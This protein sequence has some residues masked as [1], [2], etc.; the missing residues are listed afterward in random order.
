MSEAPAVLQLTVAEVYTL[1]RGYLESGHVQAAQSA[2]ER[3]LE[4]RP[5]DLRAHLLAG[6]IYTELGER[7]RAH[8]HFEQGLSADPQDAAG[9]LGLALLSEQD[10][11]QETAR[12]EYLTVA[13]LE[14]GFPGLWEHLR[15]RDLPSPHLTRGT[16]MLQRLRSGDPLGAL[17]EWHALDE[18]DQAQPWAQ[19]ALLEAVWMAGRDV[20]AEELARQMLDTVPGSIK[21]ALVLSFYQALHG[22]TETAE[23]VLAELREFDPSG[24]YLSAQMY[25]APP[26]WQLPDW[27]P[28]VEIEL[29]V[30]QPVA[31]VDEPQS[32]ESYALAADETMP[33]EPAAETL[34][35]E[36]PDLYAPVEAAQPPE[37]EA[38]SYEIYP[39]A[40]EA[41]PED[42]HAA[43]FGENRDLSYLYEDFGP[44]GQYSGLGT[45]FGSGPS[46]DPGVPVSLEL[47][48]LPEPVPGYPSTDMPGSAPEITDIP[49]DV[50]YEPTLPSPDIGPTYMPEPEIPVIPPQELPTPTDS[51]PD[52][53]VLP[54]NYLGGA[55][56]RAS[57]VLERAEELESAGYYADALER[58]AQAYRHGEV[59]ASVLLQRVALLQPH[60]SGVAAWHKLMGDLYNRGG[61]SRRAMREY[62]LA[63]Q[64]R[65]RNS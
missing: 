39:P 59:E 6:E 45:P 48:T 64:A 13:Q 21:P 26:G 36:Y 54:V 41:T 52:M 35:Q 3:L 37:V 42:P 14:P 49:R 51:P 61:M 19:L 27:T 57:P 50:E 11:D 38:P 25:A 33:Q 18:T 4:A 58:Y 62:Q 29:P 53:P 60:L 1:V 2:C 63:L 17:R 7:E 40:S 56:G 20:E 55:S 23:S 31:P 43:F 15:S 32:E 10:G 5:N 16:L 47:P 46:I 8:A 34:E 65:R 28:L 9:H 12:S 24:E 22:D 44:G 30:S